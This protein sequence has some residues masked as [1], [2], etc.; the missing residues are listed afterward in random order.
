MAYEDSC[1][2]HTIENLNVQLKKLRTQILKYLLLIYFT[3]KS[4]KVK[5]VIFLK[6]VKTSEIE[7]LN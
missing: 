7:A 2:I 6:S 1:K 5:C 4:V 3:K